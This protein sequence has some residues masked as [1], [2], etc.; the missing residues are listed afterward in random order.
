M[1]HEKF[2]GIYFAF[3]LHKMNQSDMLKPVHAYANQ[4]FTNYHIRVRV[5]MH[6]RLSIFTHSV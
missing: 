4:I 2:S 3:V 6:N 5:K 1:Q